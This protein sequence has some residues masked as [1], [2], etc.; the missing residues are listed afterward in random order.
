MDGRG[1]T[2]D[3]IPVGTA[4]A[5]VAVAMVGVDLWGRVN[6]APAVWLAVGGVVVL[7]SLVVLAYE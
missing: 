3:P 4:T 5:A 6:P 7:L 2:S 1:Q